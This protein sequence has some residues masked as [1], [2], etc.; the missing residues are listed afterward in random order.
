M[1]K[2]FL[3]AIFLVLAS[4]LSFAQVRE[5][6]EIKITSAWGGLGPFGQSELTITS[7][8][9]G[10]YSKNGKVEKQLV[11][12]LLKAIDE[13]EIKEPSLSNLGITQEWLNANAEKGIQEYASGYFSFSVENQKALYYST[14]KDLQIMQKLL[15]SVFRGGWTDDYPRIEIKITELDG[16]N[17]IVRSDAQPL[18]MLPWE[19]N[20]KNKTFK[21]YNANIAKTLANLLPKNFTNRERLKGDYLSSKMANLVM[22]FIEDDWKRLEV[23]NKASDT[24]IAIKKDYKIISAEMNSNH[25][26]DFGDEWEKDKIL[27]KNI[28]FLLKKDEFPDNFAIQLKLTRQKDKVENLNSFQNNINKYQSLIFSVPW[29]KNYLESGKQK[30]ELRFIRNRSFSEK[31]MKKF[32]EDMNKIGKKDLIS[33]IEGQKENIALIG[34]GGWLEYYQSYWLVLPNKNVILWRYRYP[35]LM[36]WNEKDFKQGECTDEI[37]A[38]LKCIGAVISPEGNIISR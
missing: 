20:S 22:D 13:P 12:D 5:I 3:S 15:P 9:N 19:I 28:H 31:A 33:E 7:K 6:R 11:D 29:L 24:F 14:F 36:N 30:V 8:N 38:G 35:M 27:E 23:E 2:L 18:F 17:F 16:T 1:K 34:V 21:T 4:C 26:I 37:S 25:G 32:A 10:Y